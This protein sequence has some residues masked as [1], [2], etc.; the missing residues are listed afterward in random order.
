M[1]I[2]RTPTSEAYK[3]HLR[4]F[5]FDNG[6]IR[7]TRAQIN[8][9]SNIFLGSQDID[10]ETEQAILEVTYSFYRASIKETINT[11]N[12]SISE[13]RNQQS[14]RFG[15]WSTLIDEMS[16][17]PS[18]LSGIKEKRKE[19]LKDAFFLNQLTRLSGV[20]RG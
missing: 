1:S 9:L 10:K 14:F 17:T 13:K 16:N 20:V 11:W 19:A 8:A 12:K 6:M 2:D 3:S 18:S 7:V 15:L 5:I 4:E